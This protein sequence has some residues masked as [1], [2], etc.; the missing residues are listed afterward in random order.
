MFRGYQILALGAHSKSRN[1]IGSSLEKKV[2]R[3][4]PFG[5]YLYPLFFNFGS[6]VG[7]ESV[8]LHSQMAYLGTA[9]K[10]NIVVC[11]ILFDAGLSTSCPRHARPGW[12]HA[13]MRNL[14][15]RILYRFINTGG[16][17]LI[18]DE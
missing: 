3:E 4:S 17:S 18:E 8:N 11:S 5:L 1:Y 7:R 2:A 14:Y 16:I 12:L 15:C 10:T 9:A 13:R 6:I